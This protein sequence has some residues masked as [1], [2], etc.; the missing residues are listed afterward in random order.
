[1]RKLKIGGATVNQ[2]PFDWE[3]NTNN[4]VEAIHEASRQGISLLCLPELCVTGYGCEDVFLSDWLPDRAWAELVRIRDHCENIT[5]AVGLPIRIAGVTYNGACVISNKKL[6][7]ISLKQ[8]LARD[9]VHY[10]PR[11]FD[12][13]PANKVSEIIR[14]GEKISVGDLIYDVAGIQFGFEIC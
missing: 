12:P 10:E 5:V 11:W 7:G 14:D 9:G 8:N 2:I 6:L 4:I 13:W 3:N 1:M